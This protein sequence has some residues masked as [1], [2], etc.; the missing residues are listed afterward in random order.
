MNWACFSMRPAQFF[1]TIL[2]EREG[3]VGHIVG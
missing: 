1:T 3:P 2:K